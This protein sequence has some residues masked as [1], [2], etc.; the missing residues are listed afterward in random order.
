MVATPSDLD[1]LTW[2]VSEVLF[3]LLDSSLLSLL[4]GY[5]PMAVKK[6]VN[7]GGNFAWVSA[8]ADA[9]TLR[10]HIVVDGTGR[11]ACQGRLGERHHG[12]GRLGM[13]QYR[14][15]GVRLPE[16]F[17]SLCFEFF[18]HDTGAIP[19]QDVRAGLPL[20]IVPQVAVRRRRRA[21]CLPPAADRQ[22]SRRQRPAKIT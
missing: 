22:G 7:T 18:V 19:H 10:L 5:F 20:H 21:R 11:F 9:V 6:S 17:N 12:F 13:H 14:G 4:L 3:F 8:V 2:P 1:L 15:I 16:R